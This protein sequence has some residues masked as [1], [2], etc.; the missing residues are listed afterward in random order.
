MLMENLPYITESLPGIGGRLRASPKDFI[1]EEISLYEPSGIGNHLYVNITKESL[2]TS[3]VKNMLAQATGANI[4]EIGCAGMKDKHALTTQTFSIPLQKNSPDNIEEICKKIRSLPIRLNWAKL[5]KN[6]LRIG[7]L[8]G[9]RFEIAISGFE[10]PVDDALERAVGIGEVIKKTGLP[11]FF[12]PQR[13]GIEGKNPQKGIEI[14][15]GKTEFGNRWLQRFLVTSV[16]SELCNRYL[17]YRVKSGN[18]NRIVKGDIAKKYSTGGL[19]YVL[20]AEAEQ[21]RYDSKEISFTA[22]IYGPK[23]MKAKGEAEMIE[24]KVLK[25]SRITTEQLGRVGAKG[26][27]R[28]GRL[29]VPDLEISSKEDKIVLKFSLP[30]GSFAT[31]V[32]RE[33][34]KNDGRESSFKFGKEQ[35]Q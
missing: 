19:F 7:H 32:L 34:M 8:L 17:A 23:M 9:N 22:P 29:L 11:N 16:Q 21:K 33:I 1:V 28:L 5:H 3:D 18:F 24:M 25:E 35:N 6:K 13:F 2:T 20:D 27:R 31:T 30:K 14:L 15:N 4:R 26:S 10:M 12:G